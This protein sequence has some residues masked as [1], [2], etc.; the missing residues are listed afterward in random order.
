MSG[1]LRA[2]ILRI[3]EREQD[4]RREVKTLRG[5]CRYARRKA[6]LDEHITPHRRKVVLSLC[7]F[8]KGDSS[9]AAMFLEKSMRTSRG[10]AFGLGVMR[11]TV[12]RLCLA[13][14][15][16]EFL[17]IEESNSYAAWRARKDAVRFLADARV[18]EWVAE[19]NATKGV[20]PSSAD[21]HAR[22]AFE[23]NRILHGRPEC[24]LAATPFLSPAQRSWARRWRLRWK[25]TRACIKQ[26]EELPLEEMQQKAQAP[27]TRLKHFS[28]SFLEAFLAEKATPKT[29]DTDPILEPSG[30]PVLGFSY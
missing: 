12:D 27:C 13:A 22:F 16:E 5:R 10:K 28:H 11:E 24:E 18:C 8:D 21:V 9:R 29:P 3:R 6:S 20:A 25:V 19:V 1:P 17:S 14:G 7:V 26:R 23:V 4:M 30:G 2:K 15:D